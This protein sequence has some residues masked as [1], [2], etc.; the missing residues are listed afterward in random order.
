MS[1]NNPNLRDKLKQNIQN[2]NL[3]VR[4]VTQHKVAS[5]MPK[6]VNALLNTLDVSSTYCEIVSVISV[7]E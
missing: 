1:K 5:N 3:N 4:T 2:C 6:R 7:V